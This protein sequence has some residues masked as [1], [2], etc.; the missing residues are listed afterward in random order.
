LKEAFE[1]DSSERKALLEENGSVNRAIIGSQK[2]EFL[3]ELDHMRGQLDALRRDVQDT[4]QRKFDSRSFS[5][6]Q[7]RLDSVME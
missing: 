5:E 7:V 3:I 6:F 4:M 2:K 1:A